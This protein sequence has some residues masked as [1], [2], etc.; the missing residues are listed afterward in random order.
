MK[1]APLL[2]GA[3][4]AAVAGLAFVLIAFAVQGEGAVPHLDR[5]VAL[6]MRQFS[7]EHPGLRP[8][9]IGITHTGGIRA[10]IL[11]SLLVCAWHIA[12]RRWLVALGCV[13]IPLGGAAL[14]LCLKT[15]LDRPR[16]ELAW[17]D[18]AVTETNESFPSGHAMGSL[19][20]LGLLGYTLFFEVRCRWRRAV[21]GVGLMLLVL[22]IGLSRVYLRAHWA[23]DV[24]GGFAIGLAWLAL[25]LGTLEAI[26]LRST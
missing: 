16:P 5:E 21:F 9:V 6:A 20:G 15:S 7:E 17:R 24:V 26:R 10:M 11:V 13:L 22:L 3:S 23:S 12:R 4:V 14:N 19:I 2:Y 8:L 1:P 25:G 18:P